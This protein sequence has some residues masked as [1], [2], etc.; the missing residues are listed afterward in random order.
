MPTCPK[1]DFGMEMS[2]RGKW[3]W[4]AGTSAGGGKPLS[5]A[6]NGTQHHVNALLGGYMRKCDVDHIIVTAYYV[7]VRHSCLV[8]IRVQVDMC[9]VV[10]YYQHT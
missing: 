9:N 6:C 4:D 5:C 7:A 8:D 3:R 2:E 1:L 10:A